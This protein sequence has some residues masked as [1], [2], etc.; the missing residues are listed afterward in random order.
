MRQNVVSEPGKQ[1]RIGQQLGKAIAPRDTGNLISA[2]SWKVIDQTKTSGT[3]MI[4]VRPLTGNNKW[5]GKYKNA[6]RY[7][8][9][10]HSLGG[11]TNQYV[12]PITR[13]GEVVGYNKTLNGNPKWLFIV[14][15]ELKRRYG[16]AIRGHIQQFR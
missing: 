8:A 9:I 1:A 2:I 14:Q 3:A 7:A 15:D 16:K 13:G 4:W 12:V 11:R 6:A 10:H 5:K